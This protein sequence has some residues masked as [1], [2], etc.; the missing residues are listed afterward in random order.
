VINVLRRT[1][2]EVKQ[3]WS[4]RMGDQKFISSSVLRKAHL[5]SLASTNPRW[6]HVGRVPL[7][8][9]PYARPVPQQW[10]H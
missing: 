2:A 10:G 9:N 3:R 4:V 7:M 1:I 8:C 6:A 5:Q